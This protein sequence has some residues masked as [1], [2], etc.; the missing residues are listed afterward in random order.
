M[1]MEYVGK[2][3]RDDNPWIMGESYWRNVVFWD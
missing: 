3:Y 1:N 2:V